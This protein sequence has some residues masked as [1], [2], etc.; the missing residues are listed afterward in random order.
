VVKHQLTFLRQDQD[1]K[2][3]VCLVPANDTMMMGLYLRMSHTIVYFWEGMHLRMDPSL[4]WCVRRDYETGGIDGDQ[5]QT[6]FGRN[7]LR[8]LHSIFKTASQNP[9]N[10]LGSCCRGE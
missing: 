10:L 1:M 6:S 7:L 4:G 5:Q 9:F 2:G 8:L 3:A